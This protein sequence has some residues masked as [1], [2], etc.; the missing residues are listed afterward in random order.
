[1]FVWS[2]MFQF[3]CKLDEVEQNFGGS[4][5]RGCEGDDV[6]ELCGYDDGEVGERIGCRAA[7][8]KI[9]RERR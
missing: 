8:N 2:S 3:L 7:D 9:S 6:V 4:L 5:V 1:M